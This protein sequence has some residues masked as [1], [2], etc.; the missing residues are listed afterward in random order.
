MLELTQTREGHHCFL[1]PF[2][3]RL[4]H[5]GLAALL[6][7]RLSRRQ[8][9]TF[10]IAVNDYGLELLSESPFPF[11]SAFGNPEALFASEQLASDALESVNVSE[12]AKL[13][14]REIARVSGL[15][16]QNF[17][18]VAKTGKQLSVNSSLLFDVL[19]EFD[20]NNLLIHQARREV[21]ERHFEESRLAR[22]LARLREH[23][24]LIRTTDRLT[25]LSLPL[26]IERQAA[27]LSTETLADR[28]RK[29]Q[30]EWT[31]LESQTP[32]QHP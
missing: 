30:S 14:F 17:P 13:Q 3:G 26:V 31:S 1:F 12:L 16:M 2:E 7:L 29:L 6:A 32:G 15:V 4:V 22:T 25:P 23:P 10:H 21:L 8:R 19:S 27:T 9:G 5:A 28:V 11:A 18:G 24:L 20:P